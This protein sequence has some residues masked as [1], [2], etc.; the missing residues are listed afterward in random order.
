[1]PFTNGPLDQQVSWQTLYYICLTE[2]IQGNPGQWNYSAALKILTFFF[3][4]ENGIG[5][6]FPAKFGPPLQASL[7]TFAY[8]TMSYIYFMEGM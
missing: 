5:H 8:T 7:I 3:S 2:C 6:K 4:K 1:M